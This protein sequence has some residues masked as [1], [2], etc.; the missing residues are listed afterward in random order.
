[1][2]REQ[3]EIAPQA[4]ILLY[5][6]IHLL[7][8][9]TVLEVGIYNNDCLTL[10]YV[11]EHTITCTDIT[12]GMNLRQFSFR[13]TARKSTDEYMKKLIMKEWGYDPEEQ[14]LTIE[15]ERGLGMAEQ[16]CEHLNVKCV[17]T[18]DLLIILPDGSKLS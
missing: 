14:I 12:S 6:G 8:S 10:D 2:I 15:I 1:M 17:A 7:N 18:T 13:S 9:D 16:R 5:K 11:T 4:Q 3:T